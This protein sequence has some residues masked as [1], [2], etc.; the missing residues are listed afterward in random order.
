MTGQAERL[1]LRLR[2]DLKAAMQARQS[3]DA[4]LLR[5]IMA[6]IDNAEA[7]PAADG[8]QTRAARFADGSAEVPRRN[9]SFIELDRLLE[10][11]IA[12]RLA[13]AEDYDR[14][15]R[16]EEAARLR[17]ETEIVRRYRSSGS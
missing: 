1:K 12:A 14:L 11:E 5:V 10:A 9:L 7:V 13:A 15:A 16:P 17:T 8:P 4:R 2:Q 6:A 3:T